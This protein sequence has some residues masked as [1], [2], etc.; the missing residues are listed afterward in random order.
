MLKNLDHTKKF[1]SLSNVKFG[2]KCNCV[3]W[4][5][6]K[7][8][9]IVVHTTLSNYTCVCEFSKFCYKPDELGDKINIC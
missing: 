6:R 9:N 4:A 8:C 7:S 1:S 5:I 3:K 2:P